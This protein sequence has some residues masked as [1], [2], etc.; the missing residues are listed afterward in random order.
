MR[1]AGGS[2]VRLN[3]GPLRAAVR[4]V[5]EVDNHSTRLSC[6][7]PVAA[8]LGKRDHARMVATRSRR[9]IEFVLLT[10]GAEMY[11]TFCGGAQAL[12][13][14]HGAVEGVI[15]L[16]QEA[17]FEC[18]PQLGSGSGAVGGFGIERAAEGLP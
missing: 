10:D 2:L 12:P 4:G 11:C 17:H 16:F 18:D 7:V 14:Q 9:L 1:A 5:W 6:D 3:P 13:A 15:L 8:A